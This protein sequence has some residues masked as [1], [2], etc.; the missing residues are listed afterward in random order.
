MSRSARFSLI[1]L[2]GLLL[3]TPTLAGARHAPTPIEGGTSI[4]I[5]RRSHP[6]LTQAWEAVQ[7]GDWSDPRL[8]ELEALRGAKLLHVE[9]DWVLLWV[10]D[11]QAERLR[12]EGIRLSPPRPRPP[13]S[14]RSLVQHHEIAE[15]SVTPLQSLANAVDV[16]RMMGHLDVLST[17]L[18]TRYYSTTQMQTATQYVYDRFVEYGLTDVHFDTFT[19]NGYTIRNVIGVKTG[20]TYPSRLYMVCG[21]LDSTSPQAGTLAPGAEDNGTGSVGVLEAARLLANVRTDATIYFV[22]FTAEE[23]GLIGSEHLAAIADQQNWDLRGVLNMDMIGYDRAGAPDLWIEG[24]PGNAGSIALMDAL[25]NVANTY[26]DMS[27]YRY[28][29]DGWGSDHEPFN[30]HGFPAI[31]AIDYDWDNYACY[32]Q[33]CDVVDNV[34]PTQLRR[35]AVAVT[36]TGAQ[37]TGMQVNLGSIQGVA[38]KTDTSNDSGVAIELAGTAYPPTTSGTTGAFTLPDLMPGDYTLRASASGY[39]TATVPVSVTEGHVTNLNISLDPIQ[40]SVVRGTV[41]LQGGGLPVGTRVFAEGQQPVAIAGVTGSYDLEPVIPGTV[42]LSANLAGR[43]PGVRTIDV[44]SGQTVNGVDFTLKT[45]WTFEDS[46][47]G[48]TANAG[49]QWG[50]DTVVGAHSGTKVWGTVLGGNYSNC[51]DYRLELPPL[52]LRFYTTARLHFWQWYKTEATYDGGN[53]QVSTDHGTTWTRVTPVGGYTDN[54]RG[55]C[56]PL[57]GQAGFGGTRASWSETIVDLGA[58][59]GRS[60]RVRLWFGSDGGTRDRGWYIDDVSLEGTLQPSDV[61]EHDGPGTPGIL[62]GLSIRPN[63]FQ[64]SAAIRFRAAESGPAW[65]TVFDAAGRRVRSLS[66]GSPIE[67]GESSFAW[68][69]RDDGGR[70]IAAGTYWVRVFM[71]GRTLV[72]PVTLLK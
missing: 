7:R 42:I 51:A 27:V 70:R 72:Q 40:A 6:S 25:E 57:S 28:P 59:T 4:E 36:V 60:I 44:P 19:Y 37:L 32:H 11:G 65:I 41:A 66:E 9:S 10:S 14:A 1:S 35:M 34:V 53:I 33:T 56:N 5:D 38:N 13:S 48:L 55:N 24:F 62:L 63:P 47:E 58:Y 69:G 29:Q 52:D 54:L 12:A 67:E 50:T 22:C 23:Q 71:S 3:L 61:V 17:Q 45:S 46:D 20:A 39:V 8:S 43:M 30:A 49:W 2:L 21:H 16:D 68:D 18:Q 26:T 31:L 64:E 15:R